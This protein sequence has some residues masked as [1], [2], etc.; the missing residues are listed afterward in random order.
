MGKERVTRW[1]CVAREKLY[2]RCYYESI[3]IEFYI[4]MEFDIDVY[5]ILKITIRFFHIRRPA[6]QADVE[7]DEPICCG[8]AIR[9][10]PSPIVETHVTASGEEIDS[11]INPT[12]RTSK[13]ENPTA[14]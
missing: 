7:I 14:I 2:N 13:R 3:H 12:R 1:E 9:R 5:R 10:H 11:Q 8:G 6:D 4:I